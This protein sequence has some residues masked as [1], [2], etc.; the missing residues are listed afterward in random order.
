[1]PKSAT[2]DDARMHERPAPMFHGALV[3][4]CLCILLSSLGTSIANVALPSLASVFSASFEQVQWIVL[5]YLLA[6]TTLVVSAGRL[7]DIIGRRRLLL[8]GLF[9]FTAAS[10][11]CAMAPTFALLV[12]ARAVQGLGAAVMAALGMAMV[13]EA[14]SKERTGSAMGLLGTMSAVGTALGPSLGGFLISALGWRSIFLVN[15]PLSVL[16]FCLAGRFLP[17]DGD[18]SQHVRSRFDSLGT[19]LLAA[20][21]ASYA[22][23]MTTGRSAS[24]WIGTGLML[25]TVI[26]GGLFLLVEA[27]VRSPL[28]QLAAFR[29][30]GLSVNLATSALVAT[31]MMTTFVVGPFYLAR[32]LALDEAVIGVVMAV[33][34]VISIASGVFAGRIVDRLGAPRLIL[35]GLAEMA[36]GAIVLSAAGPAF[37]VAGYLAGIA[38]LTP[39]YQL[40]QAANNTAVMASIPADRRGVTSGL[41]TLSRN[42]GL[43]TG[44]S[45]MGAVFHLAA[46]T[47]DIAKAAAQAVSFG[48][49]ATFGTAALLMV[50]AIILAAGTRVAAGRA[51]QAQDSH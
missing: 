10:A 36:L 49:E 5:A 39:G 42:L 51:G 13:G 44:A 50:A 17:A 33:G 45:A 6:M 32:A 48:M 28:I 35:V 41:I 47:G 30:E 12:A 8:A 46:G 9:L 22:L 27:R 11:C 16:A 38:V 19:L 26:G 34:P 2:R 1:M 43:I 18:K 24:G 29:S 40:F 7:G 15:I 37:G 31:V 3:G 21:L 14:V 23:A 4:L 25:A 20:T